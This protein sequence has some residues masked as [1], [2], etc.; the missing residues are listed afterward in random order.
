MNNSGSSFHYKNL[1]IYLHPQVYE[2][3][4]DSFHLLESID[5]QPQHM[6]LEIG[7]GCGLIALACAAK[8]ASVLCTDINPYAILLVQKNI[9]ENQHLLKGSIQVKQADMFSAVK[10]DQRFDRIIF[11]PP[12]LPETTQDP[13]PESY[14]LDIA[15]LGGEDGLAQTKRF[16]QKLSSYL[17]DTG[18]AYTFIS[19]LSDEKKVQKLLSRSDL[20]YKNIKTILLDDERLFLYRLKK[21]K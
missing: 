21:R 19:S 13:L 15:T 9:K 17:Y 5:V 2:P 7:T 3:A 20:L 14:W 6:V 4:E 18:L 10:H 11:N 16:I 8:G 1:H 12:Y